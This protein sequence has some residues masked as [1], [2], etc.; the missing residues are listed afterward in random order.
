[1]SDV[2]YAPGVLVKSRLVGEQLILWPSYKTSSPDN[3]LGSVSDN[4]VMIILKTRK[5]KK[6]TK[7]L[8]DEWQKGSYLVL[9][10]TGIFGWVG[11]GWVRAVD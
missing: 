5:S 8:S 3:S 7:N 6:I 9:T 10:S 4:D 2:L 11:E 1:V